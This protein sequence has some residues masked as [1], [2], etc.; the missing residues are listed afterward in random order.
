VRNVCFVVCVAFYATFCVLC[1]IAVPRPPGKTPFAA[2]LNNNE[3]NNQRKGGLLIKCF[4]FVMESG[5]NRIEFCCVL[6]Q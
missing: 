2:E 6:P 5:E 3:N 4:V 1:L